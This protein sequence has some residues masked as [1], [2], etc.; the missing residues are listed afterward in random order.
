VP[1]GMVSIGVTAA[2]PGIAVTAKK[3]TITFTT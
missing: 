2:R 1:V 3:P